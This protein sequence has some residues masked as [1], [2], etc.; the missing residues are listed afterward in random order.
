MNRAQ[1]LPEDFK[2]YQ[3]K[4]KFNQEIPEKGKLSERA[5][6]KA[7]GPKAKAMAARPPVFRD[8]YYRYL[9]D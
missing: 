9:S 6:R 4:T 8:P 5:G 2:L 7:K 1:R 3:S